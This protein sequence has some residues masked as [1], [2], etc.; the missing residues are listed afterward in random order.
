MRIFATVIAAAALSASLAPFAAAQTESQSTAGALQ[1]PLPACN[2]VYGIVRLVELK[3]GASIDQY[4]A[5]LAAHQAWYK[6]HGFDDVI[7]SA[8]VIERDQASGHAMYSKHLILTYHY[9]KPTSPHPTKDADWAAFVK[10]YTDAS[11][12]KESYFDCV[13]ANHAPRSLRMTTTPSK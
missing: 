9:F 5:A 10:M 2:G 11:D 7:Y 1:T 3:P 8:R 12:L 13:P 6:K 4:N